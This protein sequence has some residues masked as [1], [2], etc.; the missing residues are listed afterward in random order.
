MDLGLNQ[1]KRGGWASVTLSGNSILHGKTG[2]SDVSSSGFEEE[3]KGMVTALR[4]AKDK[5]CLSANFFCDSTDINWRLQ[6]GAGGGPD[7]LLNIL[8]EATTILRDNPKWNLIHIFREENVV[9]DFLAH[10]SRIDRWRWESD[11]AIPMIPKEYLFPSY[12]VSNIQVLCDVMRI[13]IL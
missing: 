9:A 10:K 11:D 13:F 8:M 6:S 12:K 4:L 5:H 1:A 2:F 7:N 3:L